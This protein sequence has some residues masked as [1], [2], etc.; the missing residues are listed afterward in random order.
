[1]RL[2][3]ICCLCPT[4]FY[5]FA[6]VQINL[7]FFKSQHILATISKAKRT[8]ITVAIGLMFT[9]FGI[10]ND[11]FR[12][13]TSYVSSKARKYLLSSIVSGRFRVSLKE[14]KFTWSGKLLS[15]VRIELAWGYPWNRFIDR[16]PS[17]VRNGA[18]GS[19]KGLWN[20]S[21]AAVKG[22]N[23]LKGGFQ[24]FLKEPSGLTS[25]YKLWFQGSYGS[26]RS[27]WRL[28]GISS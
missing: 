28:Y 22:Q 2:T 15:G 4:V 23:S 8:S 24:M 21:S 26:E 14:I 9:A 11:T 13:C 20:V 5:I 18:V 3:S 19:D 12:D 7:L 10:D 17:D 1:M 27:D 25:G 16:E 6:L